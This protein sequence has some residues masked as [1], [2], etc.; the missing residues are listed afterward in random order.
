M[1]YHIF[2]HNDGMQFDNLS[3]FAANVCTSSLRDKIFS[4]MTSGDDAGA[5]AD[6]KTYMLCHSSLLVSSSLSSLN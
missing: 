3:H 6:L 1:K 2:Y 5:F 4:V